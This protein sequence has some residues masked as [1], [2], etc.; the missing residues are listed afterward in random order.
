MERSMTLTISITID[1][2]DLTLSELYVD[3]S[4]DDII[5]YLEA[6]GYIVEEKD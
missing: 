1:E 5:D 6:E 4:D 2:L 3:I